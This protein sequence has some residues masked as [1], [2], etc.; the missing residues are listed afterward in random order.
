MATLG[1]HEAMGAK[2][3][4]E[5]IAT[6]VLPQLWAMSMGPRGFSAAPSCLAD[7]S[8]QC[9]PIRPIHGVS[10]IAPSL[11]PL[12]LRVIKSLGTRVEQ[13]HTQHLRDV[14][15]IEQQTASFANSLAAG[16]SFEMNGGGGG[17]VDFESL[18]K[19]RNGTPNPFAQSSASAD[20][21]DVDGWGMGNED[22]SIVSLCNATLG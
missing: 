14:R 9:R 17:D 11:R 12:T 18:V 13:E 15:R 19:G 2:V 20:P 1:V 8:P 3:D 16:S 21:W 5:A 22:T 7:T 4:R 6:L 10:Q